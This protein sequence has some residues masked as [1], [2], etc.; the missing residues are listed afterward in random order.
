MFENS[1]IKYLKEEVRHLNEKIYKL[2]DQY[3]RVLAYLELKEETEPAKTVLKKT[4]IND[5]LHNNLYQSTYQDSFT[6]NLI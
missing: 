2:Q 3:A 6:K 1:E 4:N 5:K